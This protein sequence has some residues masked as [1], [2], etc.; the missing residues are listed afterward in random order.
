MLNAWEETVE[1]GGQDGAAPT[2]NAVV[3][4]VTCD[5]FEFSLELTEMMQSTSTGELASDQI[6]TIRGGRLY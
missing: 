1:V 2:K 5:M 6:D 4:I 3:K